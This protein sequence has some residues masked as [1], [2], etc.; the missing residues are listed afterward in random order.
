MQHGNIGRKKLVHDIPSTV[1]P[2]CEN[3]VFFIT[4]CCDPRGRNQ[5]AVKE[6]WNVLQETLRHRE[7]LGHWR[8]P[9]LLAMPDHLLALCAFDGTRPM[10]RVISDFK[11]WISRKTD[12]RWQRNFFD[13][14]LRSWES[15]AEKRKYILK[16]PVRAK[17]IGEGESWPYV[18]DRIG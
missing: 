18:V 3:E 17:C 14:R 8:V 9:L 1:V 16:N 2:N 6:V 7:S 4:I 15:A 13:H 11:S 10:R 5:L 12:V